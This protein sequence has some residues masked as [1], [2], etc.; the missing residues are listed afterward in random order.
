MI[1][2]FIADG[3]CLGF[4]YGVVAVGFGLIYY[5]TRVFHLAHGAVYMLAAYSLY[6]LLA[7]LNIGLIAAIPSALVIAAGI[8][9]G[10]EWAVY[11]PLHRRAASPSVVLISSL[12]LY[13][14]LVNLVAILAGNEPRVLRPGIEKTVAFGSVVLTR[15][16]IAQLIGGVAVLSGYWFLM[17]RSRLGRL[18]RAMADNP[19]LLGVLG[20]NEGQLRL[21]AFALGSL[22][23]GIGAVFTSLDIG[24][25]PYIG[26]PMLL[27]A[28]VACIISGVGNF[29]APA[30]GAIALG[31]I[32]SVVVYYTSARWQHSV[33]FVLLIGFLLLRPEG[34]FGIKKRL[35]E[36]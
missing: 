5:S 33:T 24:I 29:L 8:G 21:V 26:F 12:G 18:C 27:T 7:V 14:V 34:I 23:A 2:Q 28:A 4:V 25:D 16:Q 13:I 31:I 11:R 17:E 3:L 35:E 20:G 32:Q 19:D 30:V 9:I 36:M 15:I 1:L 22:L 6:L 10:A